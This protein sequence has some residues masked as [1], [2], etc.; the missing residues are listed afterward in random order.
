[1]FRNRL[2]VLQSTQVRIRVAQTRDEIEAANQLIYRNYV[3]EGFW[4]ADVE[5]IGR[6]HV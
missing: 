2:P 1:M 3:A 6:A 5:E 4:P